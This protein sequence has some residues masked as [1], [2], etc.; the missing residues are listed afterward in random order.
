M[1]TYLMSLFRLPKGVKHRLDKIQ[2][3]FLCGGGF[4]ER[5]LHLINWDSV[6]QSK[7]KG[8]LGIRNLSNF[9]RPLL[10]KWSWRFVMDDNSTWRS[11]FFFFFIGKET[12]H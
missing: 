6:C 3:D 2:R 5:K 7:E 1:P 10:G 12:I 11:V 8:G 4:L 9:N